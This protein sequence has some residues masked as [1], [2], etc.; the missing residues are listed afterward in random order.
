[1]LLLFGKGRRSESSCSPRPPEP[2]SNS[3]V[4]GLSDEEMVSNRRENCWKRSGLYT[5][6][7]PIFHLSFGQ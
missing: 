4:C 1:M 7:V 2:A 3:A 5:S 6:E